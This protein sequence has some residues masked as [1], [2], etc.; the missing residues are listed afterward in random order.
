MRIWAPRDISLVL[1]C[2]FM[3]T[4]K[5]AFL[6]MGVWMFRRLVNDTTICD[7]KEA[8]QT[9]RYSIEKADVAVF[10]AVFLG[11]ARFASS[12]FMDE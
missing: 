2:A 1:L 12:V 6:E 7:A 4:I 11:Y 5:F 8:E 10:L 3:V 9:K